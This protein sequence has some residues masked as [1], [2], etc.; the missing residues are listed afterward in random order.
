M[1]GKTGMTEE[2]AAAHLPIALEGI[3]RNRLLLA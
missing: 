3:G 2:Q 1:A